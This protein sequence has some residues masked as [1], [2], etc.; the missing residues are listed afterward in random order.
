VRGVALRSPHYTLRQ[1]RPFS[2]H[3]SGSHFF[4]LGGAVGNRPTKVEC[5]D[6]FLNISWPK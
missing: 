1:V 2:D 3:A 5:R 4:G 6:R